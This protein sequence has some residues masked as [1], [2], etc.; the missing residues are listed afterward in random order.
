MDYNYVEKGQSIRMKS[1]KMR[2]FDM[3]FK[4]MRLSFASPQISSRT[5]PTV[6]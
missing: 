5:L 4:A 3:I 2:E 1:Y 6:R